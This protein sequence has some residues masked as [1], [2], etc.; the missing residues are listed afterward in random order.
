LREGAADL[1]LASRSTYV[2]KKVGECP[3]IKDFVRLQHRSVEGLLPS[4]L[5]VFVPG[6]RQLCKGGERA[7]TDVCPPSE[8]SCLRAG[9]RAAQE[10][11]NAFLLRTVRRMVCAPV[12]PPAPDRVVS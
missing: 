1:P 4:W 8:R 2:N 3:A 6:A 5:C 12:A 11:M 10:E 9:G 7:H